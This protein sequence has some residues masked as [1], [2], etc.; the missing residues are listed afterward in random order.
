MQLDAWCSLWLLGQLL[1]GGI[2][3][4]PLAVHAQQTS[5]SPRW[6][7]TATLLDGSVYFIGGRDSNLNYLKGRDMIWSLN[8]ED[9]RDTTSPLWSQMLATGSDAPPSFADHVAAADRQN[10]RII[11]YGGS[12]DSPKSGEALW[13]LNP[14]DKTWKAGGGSGGPRT[15]RYNA[16]V[17]EAHDNMYIMGGVSTK[18]STGQDAATVYYNDTYSLS[19]DQLSWQSLPPPDT[20]KT[21]YFQ[22]TMSYVPGKNIL[23]AIGGSDGTNMIATDEVRVYNLKSR[24]WTGVTTYGK[25]PPER[26]EHSAVVS[27]KDIIVYGGCNRNYQIFYDDIWVLDTD[28]WTWTQKEVLNGP[29]GRYEHSA[30]MLGNYMLIAFGFLSSK[31]A[32]SNIYLLDTQNWQYTTQFPGLSLSGPLVGS[33]ANGMPSGVIAAIVA[34]TVVAVA[35]I[36]LG[37]VIVMRRRRQMRE[38]QQR[39]PYGGQDANKPA[40][41]ASASARFL[42]FFGMGRRDRANTGLSGSTAAPTGQYMNTSAMSGAAGVASGA[43]SPTTPYSGTGR[44]NA[45]ASQTR[46]SSDFSTAAGGGRNSTSSPVAGSSAP[47][48]SSLAGSQNGSNW[49]LAP[50]RPVSPPTVAGTSN[51]NTSLRFSLASSGSEAG[52]A[53]VPVSKGK[54]PHGPNGPRSD[55]SGMYRRDNGSSLLGPNAS[56]Q[57]LGRESW[58]TSDS[59]TTNDSSGTAAGRLPLSAHSPTFQASY[60]I[61]EE[62]SSVPSVSPLND[63]DREAELEALARERNVYITTGPKQALRIANPD[64]D[65]D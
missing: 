36:V 39:I 61:Q 30:I 3:H 56:N 16:A 25:S 8:V 53:P 21:S 24:V 43:T 13:S 59:Y 64:E 11:V 47:L 52:L 62:G 51:N 20:A 9:L 19:M 45:S 31:R 65:S 42:A 57:Q 26:R 23:V 46:Y 6:G 37:T 17:A 29:P 22:H 34:G 27:G 38:R 12:T 41:P 15:R 33:D 35:L 44:T 5:P 32:D 55:S 40:A 28:T 14:K 48:P 2:G 50:Q 18:E 7:H 4:S 1:L 63:E 49:T 58:L 54:S 60:S 10:G